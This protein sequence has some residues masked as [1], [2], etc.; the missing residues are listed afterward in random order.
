MDFYGN[1][2]LSSSMNMNN[3]SIRQSDK[4]LKEGFQYRPFDRNQNQET[5]WL[6]VVVLLK[7]HLQKKN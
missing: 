6:F 1:G 4:P 7:M 3:A 5:Q 2:N